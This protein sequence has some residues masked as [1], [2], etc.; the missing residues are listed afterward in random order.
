MSA[1]PLFPDPSN[2]L[3]PGLQLTLEIGKSS[4]C[5]TRL[6]AHPDVAAAAFRL[7]KADGETYDVRQSP[8]GWCDCE[9]KGFLRWGKPCKHIKALETAGLVTPRARRRR[10]A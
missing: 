3:P 2:P 9:C 10:R 6:E 5:I 1:S 8:A 4:Y 7:R